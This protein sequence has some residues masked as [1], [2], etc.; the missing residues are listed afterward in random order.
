MTGPPSSYIRASNSSVKKPL[1]SP[2][3]HTSWHLSNSWSMWPISFV[4]IST[5]LGRSIW[6]WARYGPMGLTVELY[7]IAYISWFATQLQ[8]ELMALRET[9]TGLF[10]IIFGVQLFH[11]LTKFPAFLHQAVL[12][13]LEP[14]SGLAGGGVGT[15]G[16][17]WHL[18]IWMRDMSKHWNG[19]CLKHK[20]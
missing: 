8:H 2:F 3:D 9:L 20:W 5:D 15:L 16:M 17:W 12:E 18:Q 19:T 7:H 1:A 4:I 6:R 14:I 10:I 11:K 13:L